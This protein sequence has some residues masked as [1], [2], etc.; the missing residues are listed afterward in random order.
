MFKFIKK[1]VKQIFC[2]HTYVFDLSFE[3]TGYDHKVIGT[4]IKCS[5]CEKI[6]SIEYKKYK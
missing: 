5:K 1:K 2:K 6:I 4:V 3:A